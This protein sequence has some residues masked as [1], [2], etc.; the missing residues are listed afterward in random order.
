MIPFMI[1]TTALAPVASG[2]LTTIRSGQAVGKEDG[3]LFFLG[4]ATGLGLRGPV[5]ALQATMKQPD[6]SIGIAVTAFGATLG[7]AVWI[8]VSTTVF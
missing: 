8:V 3:L 2:L 7:S 4:L 6:L 5:G 1:A